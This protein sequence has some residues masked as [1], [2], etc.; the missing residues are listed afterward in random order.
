MLDAQWIK[1]KL[2]SRKLN[3]KMYRPF[4]LIETVG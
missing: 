2:V 3:L 4:Q 1:S